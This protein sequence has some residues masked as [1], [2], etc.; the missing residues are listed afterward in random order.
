MEL[1]E[2]IDS[3]KLQNRSVDSSYPLKNG[4]NWPRSDLFHTIPTPDVREP[5]GSC[6]P[7]VGDQIEEQ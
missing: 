1:C 6:V 2:H 4:I 5:N 3:C 7:I